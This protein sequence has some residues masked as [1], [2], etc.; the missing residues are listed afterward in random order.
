[1][2]LGG[3]GGRVFFVGNN[4]IFRENFDFFGRKKKF[5]QINFGTLQDFQKS[6]VKFSKMF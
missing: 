4:G 6:A 2:S 1:M 3:G 5:F